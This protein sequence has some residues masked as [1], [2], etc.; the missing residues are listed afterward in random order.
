[1][2]L[3]LWPFIQLKNIKEVSNLVE[4][5][6][7]S[8]PAVRFCKQLEAFRKEVNK[9]MHPLQMVIFLEVVNKP[10]LTV[11]SNYIQKILAIGQSSASRHCKRLTLEAKDGYG[12]CIFVYGYNEYR[13]KYLELTTKGLLVAEAIRPVFNNP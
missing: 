4:T 2:Y 12:L 3:L 7:F 5:Q 1:M 9:E 6:T 10:R 8:V 11:N 13:S